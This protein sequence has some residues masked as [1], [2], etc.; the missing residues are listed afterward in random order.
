MAVLHDFKCRAC[1]TIQERT[2]LAEFEFVDCEFCGALAKKT[3]EN[4]RFRKQLEFPTGP[5]HCLKEVDGHP[6]EIRSRR[7]LREHL[8]RQST[9]KF[10]ESYAKYDDGIAGF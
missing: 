10:T 6:P 5:W 7:Q 8:K 3:F 4:F 9:D 1:G 2:V